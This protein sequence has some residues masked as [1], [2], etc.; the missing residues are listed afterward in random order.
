MVDATDQRRAAGAPAAGR[1]EAMVEARKKADRDSEA[2]G[3]VYTCGLNNLG[4]LELGT[5][6]S[7]NVLEGNAGVGDHLDLGLG[8][9]KSHGVAGSTAGHLT[10]ATGIAREE[11][12]SG[13]EGGGKDEGLG[14]L[15]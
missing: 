8:L 10:A 5:V 12:E 9:A 11:E 14:K 13:K 2:A 7:G 4:Q 1:Y 6:T 15:A 3:A